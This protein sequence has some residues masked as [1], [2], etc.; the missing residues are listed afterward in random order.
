MDY[1]DECRGC[2]RVRSGGY[3]E[4]LTRNKKWL[5]WSR[6]RRGDRIQGAAGFSWVVVFVV[7]AHTVAKWWLKVGKGQAWRW[8][9]RQVDFVVAR[10][11]DDVDVVVRAGC[12]RRQSFCRISGNPV[13]DESAYRGPLRWVVLRR[14]ASWWTQETDLCGD[15]AME[16]VRTHLPRCNCC[17][18]GTARFG[19][20]PG[21]CCPSSGM[22][23]GLS[24]CAPLP[25]QRPTG[26]PPPVSVP[27]AW[28]TAGPRGN[29]PS[30]RRGSQ[31]R[32]SLRRA[33]KATIIHS[34]AGRTCRW[35]YWSTT[36]ASFRAEFISISTF[37]C[38]EM[39]LR[40]RITCPSSDHGGVPQLTENAGG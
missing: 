35:S 4:S 37:F 26:R 17:C 11:G 8:C 31:W 32:P 3:G 23:P 40:R 22:R 12:R 24:E 13:T 18:H 34:L 30:S 10:C 39:S 36:A 29:S 25:T 38:Y 6:S 28:R 1:V 9:L 7:S 27:P 14:H 20:D 16:V 19:G 2:S 33:L 15:V 21:C 5:T